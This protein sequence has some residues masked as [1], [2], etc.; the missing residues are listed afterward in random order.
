MKILDPLAQSFYVEPP[1][2]I[3]VTSVDLYFYSK[4]DN[5]PVTVQ[6]R[7]MQLGVPLNEVYPFSEVVVDASKVITSPNASVPTRVTFESPVYLEGGKFHSICLLSNS[8]DYTVWTAQIGQP[9]V[10]FLFSQES[11]QIIVS[12]QPLNGSLFKSQNGQTWTPT[13]EEDLKFTLYRANFTTNTGNVQFYNSELKEGNSQ[14][15]ILSKDP[16]E[17]NSRRIRIGLSSIVSDAGLTVGNTIVQLGSNG[18]G[19]YVNSS[20]ISTGTLTIVNSGIGYT[21]SA[22]NLTFF[23]VPLTA[24][25]GTGKNATA[26]IT[27]S[28]GVAIGAT[29]VNGGTGY[30]IGDVLTAQTVGNDTLGRNLRLS[31]ATVAGINE[32][33]I[34]QVQG[35]FLTGAGKTVQ[36]VNNSG[37]TTTLNAS[38]GGN[39]LIND[40]EVETDGLNFKVN[41]LNH[42]MHAPENLVVI[43]E[44]STDTRPSKL[45]TSYSS[46]SSDPIPLTDMIINPQTGASVFSNFENV[47]VGSTNPGYIL[48]GD[49]I[50]S[51]EGVSNN[52]LIGITRGIDNTN[53][54]TY[55]SGTPVYKYELNGISLRRINKTHTLQDGTGVNPIDLDY[56]TLKVDPTTDGTDRSSSGPFPALYFNNSKSCGGSEIRA[57]QNIPYEIIRPIVQ[58]MTLNGTSISAA[59]R[60]VAGRSVDGSEISFEDAGVETISLSENNFLKTPRIVCSRINET[61]RLIE[62][63]FEGDKSFNLSL[64]LAT[65]SSFISPVIDLERVAMIYTSNRINNPITDYVNDNRTA[66]LKEDPSAFVYA[67]NPISLETP[68]TSIKVLVSAYVNTSSDLR[69]FYALLTDVKEDPLYYPFPGYSN[70]TSTGQV[71][72][73]SNSDGTPDKK[74]PKTDVLGFASNE[75]S[76][77]DYEFTV[78]G[79]PNFRYFS[80]KLVGSS[81]NQVYPIRMR[82]LRVIALA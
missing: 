33:V 19:N 80:I 18:V 52:T 58:T 51:Y 81:T 28:N 42:G 40:I 49:E 10:T 74:V 31:V 72:N 39:V 9:D 14:I 24:V 30:T 41:H 23:D 32:L 46:T 62:D 50:I 4:D 44:A 21:P 53:T 5:L 82:D 22:G 15:A 20:G 54:L 63:T 66:S 11:K 71:I 1:S 27:V 64:N 57:T 38:T 61:D 16:L 6:L 29:I 55:S 2:G 25:T 34:D 37:L 68:A 35:T 59:V 77:K 48:I 36:Y 43:S 12:S 13:Q 7:P 45:S 56:Y 79:L 26:D 17:T 3:F 75:L 60:T 8:S 78:N 70:L 73:F 67:T 76:F 65:S 69:A 47:G